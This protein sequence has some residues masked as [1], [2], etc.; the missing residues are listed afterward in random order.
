MVKKLSRIFPPPH[1]KRH[2][3]SLNF[4]II[5]SLNRNQ[6]QVVLIGV[7]PGGCRHKGISGFLGFSFSGIHGKVWESPDSAA[8]RFLVKHDVLRSFLKFLHCMAHSGG[9]VF[10]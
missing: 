9:G 5:N 1:L 10:S 7:P 8:V 2:Q 4:W 3:A 6:T